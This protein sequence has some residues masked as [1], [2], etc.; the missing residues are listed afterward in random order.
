MSGRPEHPFVGLP[1]EEQVRRLGGLAAAALADFGLE[2]ASLEL[3]KY[4]ENA[5][6]RVEGPPGRFVLRVHRPGYRSAE[7]IRSE[8]AWMEALDGVGI[9]TP[10]ARRTREGDVVVSVR[11]PGVPEARLCDV[12][13]FVPGRQLGSLEEGVSGDAASIRACYRELGALAAAVHAHGRAFR[14]PPG[15][16]RPRWDEGALVGDEPVFGRFTDLP[17]LE[18]A[19]REL[20]LEARARVRA[21]LAGFGR[22]PDR[23]GL[24]HGDFLPENVLVAEDGPRLIDF[25]DCG[26]GWYV[27][28]LATGL[29]PLLI[30]PELPLAR[31]GY[32]EGYRSVGSLPDAHLAVLPAMLVARGLSYL[33]WPAGRPEIEEAGRVAPL[34]AGVVTE[35][36]RRYLAGEPL[37]EVGLA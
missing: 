30:R 14:P 15:F 6:F 12:F 20:L 8:I 13:E 25:D 11:A 17:C 37:G 16:T 32:L 1:A 7:E 4:R 34:L 2:G 19:Q 9:R 10:A 31:E 27:F 24:I 23:F 28:E 36:A 5:V 29:F 21:E 33:G 22:T 35:M 18:P 3:I 26:T